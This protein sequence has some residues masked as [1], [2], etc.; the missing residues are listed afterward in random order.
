MAVSLAVPIIAGAVSFISGLF[1]ASKADAAERDA[2]AE[3]AKLQ[4]NLD[5]LVKDRQKVI[6]PFE[7]VGDLSYMLSN[8][9]A[10]LS[11]ATQSAEIQI[12]QA[13]ISLANTLD[14]VRATGSSAGGAT[15]LAQAALQS[16]KGVSASIE[17]QEA[18]NEKLKAQGQQRLQQQEMSE[19]QRIQSAEAQGEQFMFNTQ[20]QREQA[21][22]DR[23]SAQISGAEQRE[24]QAGSDRTGALTGTVGSF[25]SIAGSYMGA[26]AQGS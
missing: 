23:L 17:A 9:M 6:N 26:E 8:P 20:E 24:A 22:M 15:A 12:E 13:D 10:N 11:V 7:N 16:K 14:I 19:A 1:G 21:D 2:Q 5:A 3:K 18:Q 4:R 25:A